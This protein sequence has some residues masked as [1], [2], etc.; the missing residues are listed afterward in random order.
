MLQPSMKQIAVYDLFVECLKR[1]VDCLRRKTRA[2]VGEGCWTL[3]LSKIL[4]F[5][6][7]DV[8]DDGLLRLSQSTA[9]VQLVPVLHQMGLP[10]NIGPE[11]RARLTL[12]VGFNLVNLPLWITTCTKCWAD[13]GRHL[14]TTS[15]LTFRE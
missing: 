2:V 7:Q 8:I 15:I 3:H 9:H 12:R 1:A 5:F 14:V 10:R 11:G 13:L 4:D 6:E